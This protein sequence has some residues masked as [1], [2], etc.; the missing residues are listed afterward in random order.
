MNVNVSPLHRAAVEG[1]YT[2]YHKRKRWYARYQMLE[3]G[4]G[5]FR[6]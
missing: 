5:V 4:Q 6:L 1:A 2:A 3:D